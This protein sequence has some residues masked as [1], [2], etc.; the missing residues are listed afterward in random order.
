MNR[1]SPAE[2]REFLKSMEVEWQTLLKNQPVRVLSLEETTQ[3]RVR[4]P[5]RAMD[6]RWAR[7]WKPDDKQA[8]GAPCEGTTHHQG[9]YRH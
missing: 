6:T 3:A 4:W 1:L 9:F 7:T 5:D 8:I 2:K